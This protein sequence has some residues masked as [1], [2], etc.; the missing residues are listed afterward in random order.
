MSGTSTAREALVAEALGDLVLL[1]DRVE[2]VGPKVDASRQA[3]LK[4]SESIAREIARFAP[5]MQA[6]TL[7]AKVETEK[8]VNRHV[9]AATVSAREEQLR[10]MQEGARDM[11]KK[12]VDPVVRQASTQLQRLAQLAQ[13]RANPW[14]PWLTHGAAFVTGA[15]LTWLVVVMIWVR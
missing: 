3:L 4:S 14:M 15:A 5:D 11:F 2:K 9:A 13:P 12:E 6:F 8:Y 10:V 1:L 7:H